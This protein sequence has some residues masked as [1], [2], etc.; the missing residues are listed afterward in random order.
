MRKLRLLAVACS[1]AIFTPV[2][3][4]EAV[5]VEAHSL[6]RLPVK[7]SVLQLD[8]L[9]VSDYGTLLIPAGVDEVRV[10]ELVLG[11]EARIAIIPSG[12]GFNMVVGRGELASGSQITARGAPG[13]F[14]KPALPGRN[15]TLRLENLNADELSIDA[16]GGSGAPGYFGLDGANG[17]DPG[18]LWGEASRGF[19]GDNGSN[20]H[21]GAP[22]ALVRLELPAAFPAE[23]IK[24]L[25]NG[26]VGGLAGA[27]G[28]AGKGG[29][30]KG[31][32]V[33]RADG[34]KSGRPGQPGQPGAPGRDGS[35]TVQR[36]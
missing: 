25:V 8:R 26:G 35:L 3:M 27:A 4:A 17:E 33:Y 12:Q 28:L 1:A 36:L 16:R 7:T 20:G 32:L 13:T 19:N 30:S 22:G 15:L 29:A 5:V 11:H 21:D 23:H 2:V 18:C 6:L 24:V 31:C 14:L 34:G 10:G 9:E